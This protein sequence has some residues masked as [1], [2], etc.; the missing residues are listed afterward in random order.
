MSNIGLGYRIKADGADDT[1][2]KLRQLHDEVRSGTIT[3]KN[4][5]EEHRELTMAGRAATQ[6]FGDMK[7]AIAAVNPNLMEFSRTMSIFGGIAG[8]VQS[9]LNTINLA[10]ISGSQVTQE[11][12]SA[13]RQAAVDFNDYQKL[14]ASPQY[15]PYSPV[16]QSAL[17]KYKADLN[18]ITNLKKQE[19][20]QSVDT[21]IATIVSATAIV[22]SMSQTAIALKAI[23]WDLVFA[24]V[25][26]GA[27][28]ALTGVTWF[29]GA[30]LAP[31]A[32]GVAAF[33]GAYY[34]IRALNPMYAQSMD[35]LSGIIQNNWHVGSIEAQLV[36][37]FVG[38][39]LGMAKLEDDISTDLYN[40]VNGMINL[41][42]TVPNAVNSAFHRIVLPTL[43]NVLPPGFADGGQNSF[44][45]QAI[46]D[47]NIAGPS[48]ATNPSDAGL[49]G[50]QNM[51]LEDIKRE[52]EKYSQSGDKIATN[53]TTSLASLGLI[54]SEA[55]QTNQTLYQINSG[56]AGLLQPL[57]DQKNATAQ[58]KDAVSQGQDAIKS[59]IAALEQ[60][61]KDAQASAN[62]ASAAHAYDLE[63][64]PNLTASDFP[65]I[66]SAIGSVQT[67]QSQIDSA[68]SQLAQSQ[69]TITGLDNMTSGLAPVLNSIGLS[70]DTGIGSVIAGALGGYAGIGGAGISAGELAHFAQTGDYGVFTN[71]A[72]HDANP[73]GTTGIYGNGPSHQDQ[74]DAWMK[75]T[76]IHD[77]NQAKQALGYGGGVSS[78][79]SNYNPGG[80]PFG[81]LPGQYGQPP[82]I[83]VNVHNA[84]SVLTNQDL[85]NTINMSVKKAL[86]STF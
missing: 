25:T 67:I 42:N 80:G 72:K 70:S 64:S 48:T 54:D 15:G 62:A 5:R 86:Q 43:S 18:E 66:M 60:Q 58:L 33:Y 57:V 85:E 4:Y 50:P 35:E 45:N 16:T 61:L 36:A 9:S 49:P 17:A 68:K 34:L 51:T 84:G 65:D 12:S 40:F 75:S 69:A 21:A 78:G 83:T 79:S 41:V 59:N 8:T 23:Q 44:Y 7:G 73:Y 1:I 3:A 22:G 6:E 26:A 77:V 39:Y 20:I 37:P 81:G 29:A 56:V 14:L 55:L 24:G 11:L 71:A 53:S 74:I 13:Q 30:V 63:N 38:A 47:L 82:N 19:A 32:A 27:E 31:L 52:M 46:R 28:S 2:Q 10:M 76:G